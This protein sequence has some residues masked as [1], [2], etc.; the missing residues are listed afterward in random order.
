[1]PWRSNR[2]PPPSRAPKA[3]AERL[4]SGGEAWQIP[5]MD[6]KVE[7]RVGVKAS[8][9][10]IWSHIADLPTW[11]DWNPIETN[12]EGAIAYG[13]QIALSEAVPG[14]PERRVQVRVAEWRPEAQLVWVEKRGLWFN[15]MR[16]YEIDAL[17]PTNCILANGII[18]SGLRG[19]G[20]HEK[21]R[22]VLRPAFTAIGE[23]LR[24]VAEA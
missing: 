11:S 6:F 22:K 14:L 9:E 8:A 24:Q 5:T 7:H 19:E 10:R 18:F 3:G 16:Y 2:R 15:V 13:G 23:G 20:F 1:M 12:L 17:G 4:S 21:H